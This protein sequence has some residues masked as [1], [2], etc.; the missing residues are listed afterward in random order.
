MHNQRQFYFFLT[1]EKQK[2]TVQNNILINEPGEGN[3]L[4]ALEETLVLLPMLLS[5][6]AKI[7]RATL[8]MLYKSKKEGISFY[9]ETPS[10]STPTDNMSW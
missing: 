5:Q 1:A 8:K 6:S 10:F 7:N 4:A 9:Y 3:L 2:T